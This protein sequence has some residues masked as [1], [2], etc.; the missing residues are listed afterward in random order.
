MKRLFA[1]L[2]RLVRRRKAPT[3]AATPDWRFLSSDK[4]AEACA[5]KLQQCAAAWKK[6]PGLLLDVSGAG[7][8]AIVRYR[9]SKPEDLGFRAEIEVEEP[10]VVPEGLR[11]GDR[12]ELAVHWSDGT[13]DKGGVSV[14]GKFSIYFGE[15]GVERVREFWGVLPTRKKRRPAPRPFFGMLQQCCRVGRPGGISEAEFQ[16]RLKMFG[17]EGSTN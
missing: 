1:Q 15:R 17:R 9:R 10:L 6:E 7:I 13:F 11:T 3:G 12:L 16:K 4:E 2:K 14:P 8:A 5:L